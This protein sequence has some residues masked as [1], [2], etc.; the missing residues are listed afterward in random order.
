MAK[1]WDYSKL[2]KWVAE[3]GGVQK[4]LETMKNY[5]MEE[6]YTAGVASQ[7]PTIILIGVAGTAFGFLIKHGYDKIANKKIEKNQNRAIEQTKVN[8]A[9]N[10]LM[11]AMEEIIDGEVEANVN[12]EEDDLNSQ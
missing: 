9:E 8:Q 11:N 5:Y 3:Q 6:G 7:R 1:D 12:H 2:T 4:A 10:D